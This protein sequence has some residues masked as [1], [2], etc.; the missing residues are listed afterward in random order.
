MRLKAYGIERIF[1]DDEISGSKPAFERP[2]FGRMRA[3][4]LACNLD[5]S[6]IWVA[7]LSR[8]G[9]SMD[10]IA[11]V[12]KRLKDEGI[13]VVPLSEPTRTIETNSHR[14]GF[15]SSVYSEIVETERKRLAERNALNNGKE[16]G[17]IPCTIPRD[18]VDAM[19]K[20]G[21]RWSEI[22]RRLDCD[23]STLFRRRQIWKDQ[24][25]LALGKKRMEEAFKGDE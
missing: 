22:A 12:I 20:Q 21:L 5:V 4:Y 13:K 16:I 18:R 15:L 25:F 1:R 8:L 7:D 23:K 3:A 11:A 24:D 14:G 19:R 9:R 2:G 10:E 6:Q 17:R